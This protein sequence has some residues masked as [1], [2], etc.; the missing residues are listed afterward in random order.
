MYRILHYR[1]LSDLHVGARY[2]N[3]KTKN[4]NLMIQPV[5]I[6]LAKHGVLTLTFWIQ[7]C[8]VLPDV[9]SYCAT[10]TLPSMV[11]AGYGHSQVSLFF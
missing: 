6:D 8:C 10:H 2:K 11:T 7:A 3:E 4:N 9:Q 1:I 5:Q